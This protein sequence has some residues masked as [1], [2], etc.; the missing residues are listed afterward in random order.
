MNN[1]FFQGASSHWWNFRHFLHHAKP[2][3]IKVDPDVEVAN[4]FL[5]GETLPKLFGSKR[6]GFMPYN[7]QHIYFFFCKY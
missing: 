4:I 2:N 1:F 3:I 7:L 5:L 6:R